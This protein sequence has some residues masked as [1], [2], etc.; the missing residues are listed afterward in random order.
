VCV[1]FPFSGKKAKIDALTSIEKSIAIEL[2]TFTNH[3]QTVQ[4]SYDNIIKLL[5]E[6]KQDG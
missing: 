1:P 2:R 4:M 6:K 3:L 5:T